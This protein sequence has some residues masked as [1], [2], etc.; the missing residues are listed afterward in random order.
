MLNKLGEARK[1]VDEKLIPQLQSNILQH[2]ATNQDKLKKAN[3]D[4]FVKQQ[5]SK[6]K[7]LEAVSTNIKR[8]EEIIKQCPTDG[9]HMVQVESTTKLSSIFSN[10]KDEKKAAEEYEEAGLKDIV[11][12]KIV[13]KPKK[14]SFWKR[15]FVVAVGVFQVALGY[16]L[17]YS[18]WGLT[19]KLGA[20][21][22]A[23]GVN[24]IYIGLTQKRK[25]LIFMD[26]RQQCVTI[27][28]LFKF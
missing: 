4:D 19:A 5:E 20:E 22:I 17:T 1:L 28:L 18:T 12:L 21:L 24:D 23:Q 2:G 14:T 26:L 3:S 8:N 9:K 15:F 16:L 25:Y 7:N 6:I 11:D 10:N 13:K 27:K